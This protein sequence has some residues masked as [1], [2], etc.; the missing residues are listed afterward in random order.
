M[1]YSN[2]KHI[3]EYFEAQDK[4]AAFRLLTYVKNVHNNHFHRSDIQTSAKAL[5][6]SRAS[7]YK[8]LDQ[9]IDCGACMKVSKTFYSFVSW[10]K[11]LP[12]KKTRNINFTLKELTDIKKIKSIYY[13]ENIRLAVMY[14]KKNSANSDNVAR[15]RAEYYSCS[16]SFVKSCVFLNKNVSTIS[17]QINKCANYGFI[18]IKKDSTFL[19]EGSKIDCIFF[20]KQ[21]ISMT[22]NYAYIKY[23]KKDNRYNVLKPNANLIT[24]VI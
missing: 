21:Y 23:N 8:A 10:K 17:R 12:K 24:T 22:N 18:K 16:A 20:I 5:K 4:L 2:K 14:S 3:L 13:L 15:V 9:L 19:Y 7:I 11:W 1:C 6:L